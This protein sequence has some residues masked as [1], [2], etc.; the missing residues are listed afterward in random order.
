M[1]LR[2]QFIHK[3]HCDSPGSGVIQRYEHA[4][5]RGDAQALRNNGGRSI[6]KGSRFV[7]KKG[8]R[9]RDERRDGGT[10]QNGNLNSGNRNERI[11]EKQ[12]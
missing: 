4:A 11:T 8:G 1:I 9:K 6:G 10:T 5:I 3:R 7:K 2:V 12:A